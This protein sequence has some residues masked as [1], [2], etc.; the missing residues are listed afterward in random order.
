MQVSLETLST[1]LRH[2]LRDLPTRADGR[3][4]LEAELSYGRHRGP[5]PASTNLAAVLLLLYPRANRWHIPL[6]LRPATMAEHA[7]Q[8]SFPGGMVEPD[9]TNLQAALRETNEELGIAT[10]GIDIL[11]QLSDSYVF[12]TNY[13]VT[14]WVGILDSE[15]EWVPD[16]HEVAE[17]L[18][19]PLTA[20]QE[21]IAIERYIRRAGGID[22]GVPY[23]PLDS[24]R[25]W[26]ATS[27]MLG[28][29]A[30]VLANCDLD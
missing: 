2:R 21:P 6:T 5:A 25:I 1:S 13:L 18:H 24:H 28:E 4:Q 14:P 26:G 15:P 16:P 22:F 12:I 20:L 11:G 9:E 19:L 8:V 10:D 17:V 27:M 3:E 7:G 23:L 29:F 30:A